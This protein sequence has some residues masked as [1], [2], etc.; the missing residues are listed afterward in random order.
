MHGAPHRART[1][2][3]TLP[4]IFAQGNQG[5][6]IPLYLVNIAEHVTRPLPRALPSV[7]MGT[8]NH[9]LRE[10][11]TSCMDVA[12]HSTWGVRLTHP[13]SPLCLLLTKRHG[14][15]HSMN[16]THNIAALSRLAAVPFAWLN[17]HKGLDMTFLTMEGAH[18]R[19]ECAIEV[20]SDVGETRPDPWGS[21][22]Q[23]GLEAQDPV[24]AALSSGGK[25]V[26]PLLHT[27]DFCTANTAKRVQI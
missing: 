26:V 9:L 10:A 7:S 1:F 18:R 24:S 22:L 20:T 25:C 23:K 19:L 11:L 21:F 3:G 16:G 13:P 2:R 4:T 5:I 17:L 12:P 15:F 27:T 6:A 14:S 8:G